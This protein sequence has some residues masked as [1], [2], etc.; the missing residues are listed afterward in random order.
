MTIPI[1]A[2]ATSAIQA[3][4]RIRRSSRRWRVEPGERGQQARAASPSTRRGGAP[5]RRAGGPSCGRAGPETRRGAPRWAA[6]SPRGRAAARRRGGPR[7]RLRRRAAS[8]SSCSC[9]GSFLAARR[10]A[11]AARGLLGDLLGRGHDRAPRRAAPPR[12]RGRTRTRA[13]RAGRCSRARARPRK[14]LTRRS[15][16]EWKEIPA[17]TPPSRSSPQASGSARS[18]WPSSSLTAIRSAWKERLAG[19]PP[20]KRAGAGIAE[21][22]VSTSSSVVS[23][24][25]CSRRRTIARAI[26]PAWRSSPKSRSACARRRS[27]HSA[28]IS[29]ALS[30]CDGV[31]AHVQRRVV[32]V[33]EA[34]LARV[35]LHRGHAQVEVR[36]VRAHALVGEQLQRLGVAGADEAHRAGRL[37]RRARRSAPR[38]AGRGRSPSSVPRRAEA[39]GEQARVPAVA[40]GAVDRRL[41]GLRV[42]QL[43]QLAREHRRVRAASARR[44]AWR[45]ARPRG[46]PAASAGRL[47]RRPAPRR[48]GR[49][50]APPGAA[51]PPAAPSRS[52]A[53]S[54]TRAVTSATP[55]SSVDRCSPQAVLA[56]SSRRSPTPTTTTS[57][58][59]CACSPRKPG[60]HDPPGGVELGVVGAAVEEALELGQP[61]RQRRQ[62]GQR[63]PACS[64]RTPPGAT[65][66]RR[67][68]GRPASPAPRPRRAR[69][70][71]ARAP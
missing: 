18:S 14:R 6:A 7:R 32:G 65:R 48:A 52:Q 15:S 37:A 59:S 64:A 62:L 22:I 61:R 46:A 58:A 55:L 34:A 27:S 17:S 45:G 56:H 36:H 54:S 11:E 10:R 20:A 5:R 67:A 43:E 69:R 39:L 38:R 2:N 16:S 35:D 53:A 26:A 44:R 66:P 51:A 33:G 9:G 13:G 60:N 30:S 42:E 28:T 71:S 70:G 63:A 25:A 19:W 47:A 49:R 21:L 40:E 8:S 31:H 57:L 23:I 3:R 24:G 50:S 1:S 41:A 68:S 29:R 4:P 12:A